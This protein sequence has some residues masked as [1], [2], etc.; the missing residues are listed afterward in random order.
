MSS[1]ITITSTTTTPATATAAGAVAENVDTPRQA[2]IQSRESERE[3]A[4]RRAVER[5]QQRSMKKCFVLFCRITFLPLLLIFIIF[6]VVIVHGLPFIVF[7]VIYYSCTRNPVSPRVLFRNMLLG[8]S[9]LRN[10]HHP[11]HGQGAF[12]WTEDDIRAVLIRRELVETVVLPQEG[13]TSASSSSS[14]S[15][16]S[17]MPPPQLGSNLLDDR[18]VTTPTW[19]VTQDEKRLYLFTAPLPFLPSLSSSLTAD[20]DTNMHI[21]TNT[22]T[23]PPFLATISGTSAVV[24]AAATV[25]GITS[26]RYLPAVIEEDDTDGANTESSP[27]PHD[28]HHE[29]ADCD[30]DNSR[31]NN[32]MI[33]GNQDVETGVQAAPQEDAAEINHDDDDDEEEHYDPHGSTCD[34]CLCSYQPGDV[35]AWSRNVDCPHYFHADCITDWLRRKRT[36]CSCRRDYLVVSA[37]AETAKPPDADVDTDRTATAAAD[38]IV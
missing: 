30:N 29:V 16:S 21:R 4:S 19:L 9:D 2:I 6:A 22:T 37:P 27:S 13:E 35:V 8:I 33:M 10:P 38:E 12:R 20:T 7:I 24:V 23:V 15:S 34:I 3:R 17:T 36:C 1:T 11:Q 25:P 26:A 31:D 28:Q 14:S 5:E 18:T 32:E